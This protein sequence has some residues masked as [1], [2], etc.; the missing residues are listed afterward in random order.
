MLILR[1]AILLKGQFIDLLLTPMIGPY[2]AYDRT[3]MA[4][5]GEITVN[6]FSTILPL[7]RPGLTYQSI[8]TN[9]KMD[10]LI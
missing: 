8:K 10:Q 2:E 1:K 6:T 5:A 9:C 4:F 3:N 7:T